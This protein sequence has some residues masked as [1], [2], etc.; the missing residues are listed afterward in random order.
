MVLFNTKRRAF[1][2]AK[3]AAKEEGLFI[4]ISS[5]A[6]LAAIAKKLADIPKGQEFW[7]SYDTGERYLSVEDNLNRYINLC[8]ITRKQWIKTLITVFLYYVFTE[9]LTAKVLS[10]VTSVVPGF[11]VCC[12]F[13][14]D[15]PFLLPFQNNK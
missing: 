12:L 13:P 10:H 15:F 7:K 14:P 1:D 8:N 4:G 6:T 11:P 5:G 9:A 3:K 2:Y